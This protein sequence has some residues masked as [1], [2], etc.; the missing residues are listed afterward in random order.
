MAACLCGTRA[1][2]AAEP[3]AA[4]VVQDFFNYL[5]KRKTDIGSDMSAQQK[6][7]T[8]ELVRLLNDATHAVTTA[9]R[10]PQV[11]GPDPAVPDNH[12]FLDSWDPPSTCRAPQAP[13]P[14]AAQATVRVV[15]RWGA[16]TNYPGATRNLTVSIKQ[17][18]DTWR[19]DDIEFHKSRYADEV[20]LVHALDSL[21]ADAQAL[22]AR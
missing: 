11:D 3:S 21:K 18:R 22:I 19:I 4:S 14:V 7:L 6:W 12:L 17:D 10:L 8:P 16:A 9:R 1:A 15:C 20:R 13:A 2:M 5:L